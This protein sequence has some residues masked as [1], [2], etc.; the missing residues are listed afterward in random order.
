M[1]D[2][3]SHFKD[4]LQSKVREDNVVTFAKLLG[5][6]HEPHVPMVK[7]G[8][9][10]LWNSGGFAS[11]SPQRP[12][13]LVLV[14]GFDWI[15]QSL[16][17]GMMSAFNKARKMVP[18]GSVQNVPLLNDLEREEVMAPLETELLLLQKR[19]KGYGKIIS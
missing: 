13:R 8:L 10:V 17:R 11:I 18:M 9:K 14:E 15:G 1:E 3:T 19:N 5:S 4:F 2:L 16:P 12:E 6:N 7:E